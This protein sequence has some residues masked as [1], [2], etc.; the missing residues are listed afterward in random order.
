MV[1]CIFTPQNGQDVDVWSDDLETAPAE[2]ST[3]DHDGK[4]WVVTPGTVWTSWQG[5][6]ELAH[7]TVRLVG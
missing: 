7:L 1:H 3:V 6:G 4:K 2:G 5:G